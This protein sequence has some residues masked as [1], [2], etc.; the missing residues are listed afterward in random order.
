[1]KFLKVLGLSLL[2]ASCTP[3]T[4]TQIQPEGIFGT[5]KVTERIFDD[6]INGI[7]DEVGPIIGQPILTIFTDSTV[8]MTDALFGLE[9]RPGVI[10]GEEI[11]H[12]N[13]NI[14]GLVFEVEMLDENT[15]IAK[16]I[17]YGALVCNP[18]YYTDTYVRV[19][20]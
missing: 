18:I 16:H 11:Y 19:L 1:M 6:T 13:L 15:M 12:V 8:S 9:D 7:D 10:T 14:P 5:W 4:D 2:I 17:Q 20:D 3:S